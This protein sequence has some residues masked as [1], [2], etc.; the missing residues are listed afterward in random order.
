MLNRYMSLWHG[1]L[2]VIQQIQDQHTHIEQLGQRSRCRRVFN[3]WKYCIL[4][5]TR[6]VAHFAISVMQN[7]ALCNIQE[8][9][10]ASL[11]Y[12]ADQS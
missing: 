6:S 3:H 2:H 9:L 11:L 7:Q 12:S 8:S 4:F 10:S 5:N 1:R